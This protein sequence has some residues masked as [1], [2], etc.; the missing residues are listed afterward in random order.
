MEIKVEINI[1]GKI[2]L[3]KVPIKPIIKDDIC[4]GLWQISE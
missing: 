3:L 2:E 4:S 1:N